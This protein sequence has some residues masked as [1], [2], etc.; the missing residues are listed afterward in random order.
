M[1]GLLPNEGE[2]MIANMVFKGTSVDR[3]TNLDIGLF[4]NTS[5][6][7]AITAATLTEPTGTGYAR[8]TLTDASWTITNDTSTYAAQVWTA[9]A[10]WTGSIYGYFIVS[11]GTT[12]RIVAIELNPLGPNTLA[13]ND[14]YTVTPSIIV[15]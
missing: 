13:I 11:K 8:K 12:P 6:S 7:E 2:N 4:T 5:I 15:A 1:A 9:T 14:T 3:G 10:A